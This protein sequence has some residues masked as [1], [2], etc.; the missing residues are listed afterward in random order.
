[1]FIDKMEGQAYI[2]AT[3]EYLNY[4]EGHLNNVKAAFRNVSKACSGMGWVEDDHTWHALRAEVMRHDV[5]KFSKDEFVQ[6]R[7]AFYGVPGE[8]ADASD[9]DAAW[10][11][12][13]ERN[14][15]HWET[16]ETEVDVIHMIIDWTAMSY[17]FG[18]TAQSYYEDNKDTIKIDKK[19]AD[20]MY[21]IFD[22]MCTE[23][24]EAL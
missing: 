19:R 23:D 5:S 24:K 4:M 3:R 9:F 2:D 17:E 7:A 13:M 8:N 20:F 12:H 18:G 22:R 15:H 1:M 16:V 10:A 11:H 14:H 21:K 6:Y